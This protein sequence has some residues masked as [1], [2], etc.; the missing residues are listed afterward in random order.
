[1]MNTA[2]R[3]VV[4]LGAGYAGVMSASRLAGSVKP[5]WT[6]SI[7]SRNSLR[8]FAWHEVAARQGSESAT[9]WSTARLVHPEV[10]MRRDSVRSL[11]CV[12][13]I[14]KWTTVSPAN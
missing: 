5:R 1:M 11:A 3:K 2:K 12:L 9:P 8:G 6:W 10:H 13:T 7:R 14:R 4:I